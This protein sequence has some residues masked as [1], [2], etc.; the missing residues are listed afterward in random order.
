MGWF[1]QWSVEEDHEGKKKIPT[2]FVFFVFRFPPSV[3]T[4]FIFK[5]VFLYF[6]WGP[7]LAILLFLFTSLSLSHTVNSQ[8]EKET[9]FCFHFVALIKEQ[10]QIEIGKLAGFVKNVTISHFLL[11]RV[12]QAENASCT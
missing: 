2:I 6:I 4:L 12:L 8:K 7:S 3:T 11:F 5:Y 9:S 10:L 1:A